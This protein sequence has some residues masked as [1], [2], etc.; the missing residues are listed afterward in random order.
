MADDVLSAAELETLLAAGKPTPA[1]TRDW[2]HNTS[3]EPSERS[4]AA[5]E[6]LLP[7][8]SPSLPA[9]CENLKRAVAALSERCGRQFAA[10]FSTLVRRTARVKLASVSQVTYRDFAARLASP[11][12]FNVLSA[13]PLAGEWVLE[14]GPTILYPAIDCM[15][16][17]GRKPAAVAAR[18]PTDIELRLAARVTNL[19]VRELRAA[20]Q[21]VVELDLSVTR[22]ATSPH[23][24]GIVKPAEAVIWIRFEIELSGARGTLNLGIPAQSLGDVAERL[25]GEPGKNRSLPR[26]PDPSAATAGLAPEEAAVE[27]VACLAQS[28]IAPDEV[29]NLSVGDVIT[30][31]QKVDAPIAVLRDGVIHFRARVGAREGHKALE[32]EEVMSESRDAAPMDAPQQRA[33][34]SLHRG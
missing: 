26:P 13:A 7:H 34:I 6:K 18:P 9:L 19:F 16:G 15:L 23:T 25:T 28:K 31:E 2:A 1:P 10:E 11:T 3:P 29:R 12:C 32:I 5:R 24:S 8:P 17:G 14:I 30:T 21:P 20:W 33:I 22:V 27:L 4:A